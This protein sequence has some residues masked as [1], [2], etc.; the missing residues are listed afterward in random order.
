[1]RLLQLGLQAADLPLQGIAHLLVPG[2][3][4]VGLGAKVGAARLDVLGAPPLK[5]LLHGDPPL[6]QHSVHALLEGVLMLLQLFAASGQVGVSLDQLLPALE[7]L[8]LPV[9][10][11]FEGVELLFSAAQLLFAGANFSLSHG[12]P[13]LL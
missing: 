2:Q 6:D 12:K 5:L 7:G 11:V 9:E 13:S 4:G 8:P 3:G 1:M 10:P